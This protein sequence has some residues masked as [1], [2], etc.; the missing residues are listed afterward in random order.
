MDDTSVY[1]R[2]EKGLKRQFDVAVAGT[3]YNNKKIFNVFIE[4][5]ANCT[6]ETLKFLGLENE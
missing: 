1:F 3:S 6:T 4:K 5:F 2:A